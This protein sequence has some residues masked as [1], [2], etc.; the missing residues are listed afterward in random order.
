MTIIDKNSMKWQVSH[1]TFLNIFAK[2]ITALIPFF[3]AWIYGSNFQTDA[4]FFSFG[5]ILFLSNIFA[6][7]VED[8]GVPFIVEKRTDGKN[9]SSFISSL[10][11]FSII[12]LI[13]ISFI[14]IFLLKKYILTLTNFDFKTTK[15]ILELIIKMLPLIFLLTLNS[16]LCGA[17]NAYK[18]F[19]LPPVS[20]GIRTVVVLLSM[21]F[22]RHLGIYALVFG[23]LV[24]EGVKFIFSL[25]YLRKIGLKISFKFNPEV[26]NFFKVSFNKLMASFF[27][28]VRPFI[29]RIFA[30][31]F[32]TGSVSILEYSEKLFLIPLIFF[33]PGFTS[34]VF[35]RWSEHYYRGEIEEIRKG[36]FKV[37][38]VVLFI[39]ILLTF[40]LYTARFPAVSFIYGRGKVKP[41]VLTELSG[42]FG[43]YS[44]G[45]A[46][47][48]FVLFLERIL[49]IFKETK[50]LLIIIFTGTVLKIT[51]NFIFSKILGLKGIAL[52]YSVSNVFIFFFLFFAVKNNLSKC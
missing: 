20:H 8:M 46:P 37:G 10:M 7:T 33:Y 38:A 25:F 5:T 47:T 49:L 6:L 31:L 43:M 39:T 13:F 51:L 19:H 40:I 32:S 4:F 29:D 27:Q 24:G 52:A 16:I 12:F 30:S 26:F 1:T 42:I 21:Y 2:G 50:I 36:F 3:I 22:L 15:L 35:S 45:I 11:F 28:A 48:V 17:A 18:I 23:Y 41:E 44:L 9:I 34:V 14:F